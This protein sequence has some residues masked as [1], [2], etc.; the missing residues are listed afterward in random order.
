E[1]APAGEGRYGPVPQEV[2]AWC[3]DG[4]P[5]AWSFHH[6]HL[7]PHPK[8]FPPSAAELAE[9]AELAGRVAGA[10]RSR[11]VAAD[12]A[13][14]AGGGWCFIEA[15]PGSCAG[16]AHEGF[17]KAVAQRLRGKDLNLVPDVVGG[18]LITFAKLGSGVGQTGR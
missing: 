16:T 3:V 8:G 7:V 13:R 17:F 15:G 1:L 4:V 6:L 12:F 5:T 2:R 14:L 18:P 9:I 10:F 11:L